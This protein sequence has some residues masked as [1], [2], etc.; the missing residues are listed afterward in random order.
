MN[1]IVSALVL[2][3]ALVGC[4]TDQAYRLPVEQPQ[5]FLAGQTNSYSLE[6]H[7]YRVQ[8][9]AGHFY[10]GYVEFDDQGWYH[11]LRQQQGLLSWLRAQHA[12]AP[13]RQFLIVTYIEGSV[14]SGIRTRAR[15]GISYAVGTCARQKS[16]R[17]FP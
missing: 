17:D 5:P 14:R 6:D 15:Q 1:R 10:M 7:A 12:S 13:S 11:D 4:S 8:D 3:L 16:L 2:C 9:D